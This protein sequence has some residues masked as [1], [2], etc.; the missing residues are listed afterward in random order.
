MSSVNKL[1]TE[2][3]FDLRKR[4]RTERTARN[5]DLY[6][7]RF[8]GWLEQKQIENMGQVTPELIAKYKIWL[9][10]IKNP[11]KKIYLKENT[12]NYHLIALREFIKYLGKKKILSITNPKIKLP[13]TLKVK[14]GFLSKEDVQLLLESPMKISQPRLIQLR[15]RAILELFYSTGIRVSEEASLQ[16]SDINF[17]KQEIL[18]CSGQ[19]K[20]R[21]IKFS[22]Q[23]KHWLVQY[24]E[25]RKNKSKYVFVSHDRAK[26][27]REDA[28]LSARS[29]ERIVEK[30]ARGAGIDKK[31]TPQM[32]RH[33][34]AFLLVE[35]TAD[36]RSVKQKLGHL[37]LN[38]AMRYFD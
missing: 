29:L 15:D 9:K 31:V 28:G 11:I 3:L 26:A 38:S 23:A 24:L 33:T 37:S 19:K 12:Q 14:A 21:R 35:R 22:N 10:K 8:S 36:P 7:R 1:I 2:F 25:R 16:V 4:K 32:L 27:T 5:Y 34:Y 30:Y 20:E 18:V 17:Q 13:K 6:L